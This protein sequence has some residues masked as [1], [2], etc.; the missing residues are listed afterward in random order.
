VLFAFL[1][2]WLFAITVMDTCFVYI[3]WQLWICV[4]GFAYMCK[5]RTLGATPRLG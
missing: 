3:R 2:Q 1:K 4:D 5:V